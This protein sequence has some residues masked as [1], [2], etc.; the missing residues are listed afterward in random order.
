MP[1]DLETHINT[2]ICEVQIVSKSNIQSNFQ[3]NIEPNIESNVSTMFVCALC[4]FSA[5]DKEQNGVR[6][7][8]LLL[9]SLSAGLG[10][11]NAIQVSSVKCMGSCS[12]SCVVAF[13]AP[14]KYTFIFGGLPP[15]ESTPELVEFSRQYSSHP[16]GG[17]PF[18]DRSEL[19]K[20]NLM[21]IIP[22]I[23]ARE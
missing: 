20:K 6:G 21:L 23:P 17:V 1:T 13:M 14:N 16:T 3:S 11:S 12:R 10:E 9:D 15:L 19:I 5:T 4:R 2:I 8:Q 7:G 18:G 22:P